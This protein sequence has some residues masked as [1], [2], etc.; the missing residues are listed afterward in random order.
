MS[1]AKVAWPPWLYCHH[2]STAQGCG[3]CGAISPSIHSGVNTAWS[4]SGCSAQPVRRPWIW[5]LLS[6]AMMPLNASGCRSASSRQIS[7]DMLAP[8][9]PGLCS[10][11]ARTTPMINST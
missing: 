2:T 8:S 5:S 7:P 1:R 9:T 4:T 11:A 10:P 6:Q 3:D